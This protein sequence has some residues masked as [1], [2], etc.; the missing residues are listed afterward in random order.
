MMFLLEVSLLERLMQ[1]NVILGIGLAIVGLLFSLIAK[2]FARAVR[3]TSYLEP[4][5]RLVIG[6]KSFGLILILI[7]LIVIV[8]E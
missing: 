1:K 6:M 2:R 3:K 4:N 7:A 8:I 5:D